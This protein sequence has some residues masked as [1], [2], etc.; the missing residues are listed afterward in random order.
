VGILDIIIIAV[1]VRAILAG[2]KH[3]RLVSSMGGRAPA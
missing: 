3:R 2:L 1:L